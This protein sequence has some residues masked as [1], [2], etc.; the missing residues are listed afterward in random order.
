M[1]E[2]TKTLSAESSAHGAENGAPTKKKPGGIRKRTAP[3]NI[4]QLCERLENGAAAWVLANEIEATTAML[5]HWYKQHRGL[6]LSEY[7]ARN[8]D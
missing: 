6:T 7:K 4:E 1:S 8:G 2:Y 3:A 5:Y